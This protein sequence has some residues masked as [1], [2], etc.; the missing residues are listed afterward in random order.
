MPRPTNE[1]IPEMQADSASE[2][3]AFLKCGL[4]QLLK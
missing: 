1:G 2:M 4:T 3:R